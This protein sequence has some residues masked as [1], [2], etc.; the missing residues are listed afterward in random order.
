MKMRASVIIRFVVIG[1]LMSAC[2]A[3]A[4]T[5]T[6]NPPR[7]WPEAPAASHLSMGAVVEYVNAVRAAQGLGALRWV[8]AL[9]D[10]AALQAN[11]LVS[12]G[13]ISHIGHRGAR[14][15]HRLKLANYDFRIAGENVSKGRQTESDVVRAWL[16]SPTHRDM[17]LHPETTQIGV[18]AAIGP[19]GTVYWS[20]VMADPKQTS[21]RRERLHQRL[22]F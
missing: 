14:L 13:K 21:P 20:M 19:N 4:T 10:A 6:T 8:Q 2:A 16:Q 18:A 17:M 3:P 9:D 1:L 7:G 15:E 5:R 22:P 11:H 12:I